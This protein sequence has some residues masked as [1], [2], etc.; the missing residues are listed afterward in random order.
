MTRRAWIPLLLAIAACGR[1]EAASPMAGM[2]AEEHARMMAGGTQGAVDSAGVVIRRAVQ[3]TPEQ[4]RALGVVYATV[5]REPVTRSIRTVGQIKAPEP[6][7][8]EVTTKVEAFVE[9]LSVNATGELVTRG[10]PLVT[11]YSPALVAAQEELLAARRLQTEVGSAPSGSE[12]A[13]RNA[14]AVVEAARRRLLWW[15]VPD[16]WVAELERTG[17]PQR[18]VVLRA[19]VTGVVLEKPVVLGQRVMPGMALYRIADLRQVWIEGD[20]FEQ[21]LRF[22]REGAETHIEVSAY[23]GEHLMGRV[24]FIYPTLDPVSRTNRIRVTLPNPGSRLKPGMFAT[25]YLD[26]T[27]GEALLIPATAVIATGERNVV[28]V[29]TPDGMLTPRP[30]VVGARSEGRVEILEGLDAG[31]TV[32]RSANFLVDAESRLG[33]TETGM[34]GMQHGA[35]PPPAPNPGQDHR[36][37]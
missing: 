7:I 21:D 16:D 32:V 25:M 33:G 17:T 13:Q 27:L 12:E 28:F 1:E 3:L 2:T 8:A 4:E 31:E 5:G 19:P 34:P 22:I 9:A 10:A 20:V 18:T 15:D 23:P 26:V 14:D 24:S 37:D 29:R 30:V 6:A 35:A 11:L 36:H